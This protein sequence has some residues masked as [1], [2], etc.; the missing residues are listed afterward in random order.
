MAM[1]RGKKWG[2]TMLMPA[3]RQRY[4]IVATAQKNQ[5]QYIFG[6]LTYMPENTKIPA[7]KS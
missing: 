1:K 4:Y 5:M 3:N 2:I 7:L 6:G